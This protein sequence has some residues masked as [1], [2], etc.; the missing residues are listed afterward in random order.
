MA[1]DEG[2]T[3]RAEP[4]QHEA[5]FVI[6]VV[7]IV[8]EQPLLVGENGLSFFERNSV[9]ARVRLTFCRIPFEFERLHNYIVFTLSGGR[10]V[11]NVGGGP[12]SA[13]Y[14]DP[15]APHRPFSGAQQR[16]GALGCRGGPSDSTRVIDISVAISSR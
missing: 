5:V 2:S 14:A 10:K 1:H 11:D 15:A 7:R 8:N 12:E 3:Q 6:G 9:L 13:R 16:S 4:K